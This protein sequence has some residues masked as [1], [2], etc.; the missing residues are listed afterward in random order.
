MMKATATGVAPA[1]EAFL[2]ER[3][4]AV[5]SL[6]STRRAQRRAEQREYRFTLWVVF[7]L[8]LLVALA[9][10][11][12]PRSWRPLSGVSSRPLSPV[13]EARAAAHYITPFLFSR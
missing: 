1:L 3:T 2:S 6:A 8:F 5:G 12:L 9:T 4:E 7:A 10:W 13:G 11:L